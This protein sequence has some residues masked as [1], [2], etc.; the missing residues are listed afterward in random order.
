M[1]SVKSIKVVSGLSVVL[2]VMSSAWGQLGVPVT[3]PEALNTNAGSDSGPEGGPQVTTDGAGHWVAVWH[4]LESLG[5]ATRADWDILAAR[6]SDNG[7]NWTYPEPLNNNAGTD[8][9]N[10]WN[11]Q[12]VTDGAG[13]WVAVWQSSETLGG[14]IKTDTDILMARSTDNGANWTDPEPLNTNAETDVGDDDDAQVTTDGAGNWLAVWSSTD[15][16]GGTIGNDPDILV[17]RSSD[18][19]DNWT[20]P[21]A[22]N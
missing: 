14:T 22:L 13:H 1:P 21:E 16:L 4:S 19:G 9:G 8:S 6:S 17:A 15:T 12:V 11:S 10:D 18:N 2:G 3:Y 20:Y 5:G 7:V